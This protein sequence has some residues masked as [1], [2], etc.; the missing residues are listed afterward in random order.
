MACGVNLSDASERTGGERIQCLQLSP[1][2]DRSGEVEKGFELDGEIAKNCYFT[3]GDHIKNIIINRMLYETDMNFL[4]GSKF[5]WYQ[6]H[7]LLLRS[8]NNNCSPFA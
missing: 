1:H 2:L 5:P 8:I 4:F 3:F 7:S 6:K